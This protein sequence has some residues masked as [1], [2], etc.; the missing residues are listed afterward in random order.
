[1]RQL[2]QVFERQDVEPAVAREQE[3]GVEVVAPEA[4]AVADPIETPP[5]SCQ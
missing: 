4:G 1:M 2:G 5:A 3:R